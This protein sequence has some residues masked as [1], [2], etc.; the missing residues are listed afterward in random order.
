[1]GQQPHEVLVHHLIPDTTGIGRTSFLLGLALLIYAVFLIRKRNDRLS[2]FPGPRLAGWTRL[3]S[4]AAVLTGREHEIL[5]EAHEKYG[6]IVRWS[7]NTLLISDPSA[8]PKIYHL[9]AN[10]T[11]HYNHSPGDYRGMVEENDWKEHRR[12][13]HRIDP[14]F[15]PKSVQDDETIIQGFVTN[16]IAALKE[17]YTGENSQV[18]DFSDWG[19]FLILDI[20]T[21]RFF[22]AEMGFIAHGDHQGLLADTRANGPVIHALARLPKLKTFLLKS[23]GRFLIPTA[24]DGS[25]LGNVLELRDELLGERLKKGDRSSDVGLD[26]ILFD[27]ANTGMELEELKEDLLFVILGAADTT[28]HALRCLVRNLLQNPPSLARLRK[29]IDEAAIAAIDMNNISFSQIKANIPYLASCI[30]ESLRRDPPIVSYLPRWVD[31]TDDGGGGGIELC[32]QFI[33]AGVEVACSPYVLSRN[34]DLYGDDVHDFRPE[35]YSEASNEWVAKAV[36][37]DFT[38]GYGPRHCIGQNLSHFVTCKAIVQ[39]L[40]HFDAELVEAGAGKAFLNWNYQGLMVRLKE[41]V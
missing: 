1:M 29:E 23:F 12:K 16:W 15:S 21:K 4:V 26:R 38:F 17:R 13:R 37:Y 25:G 19:N 41:R 3:H 2:A 27:P 10:K 33:P 24:G 14:P 20:V 32:G 6:P 31:S 9:R 39:L 8:L 22:G 36:R 40:H 11:P 18:F 35:R 28:G 5:L 7:P 30:R 34:K